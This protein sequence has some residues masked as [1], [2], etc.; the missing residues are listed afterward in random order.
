MSVFSDISEY[1]WSTLSEGK[2]YDVSL[3]E[4]TI[5]DLILLEIAKRNYH[6]LSIR[7]TSKD[8]ESKEGTDWEFW[9][10]SIRMGWVRYAVQAKKMD[11]NQ[12]SYKSLKH[13]VGDDGRLQHELLRE[14]AQATRS[15]AL[16][17]FYNIPKD[18]MIDKYW[19]CK[20]TLSIK[21]MG[22]TIANLEV[23]VR[24]I[25]KKRGKNFPTIH[26]FNTT[27]PLYCLL[28]CVS[29]YQKVVYKQ[30]PPPPSDTMTLSYS[31][32]SP[33]E[34]SYKS[35]FRI[36][37]HDINYRLDGIDMTEIVDSDELFK[38]VLHVLYPQNI[39]LPKRILVID[40]DKMNNSHHKA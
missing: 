12:Y 38:K 25:N 18:R 4:E 36:H 14:Y 37:N 19:N 27:Y 23:V 32:I 11:Y 9:I 26:T 15:I 31:G 24:A 21:K 8:K 1:V 28:E 29:S 16:Y 39:P 10:G 2:R 5:S 17:A 40:L 20:K 13:K 33:M 22:V 7:K 35:Q 34:L 6:Y 3:G 30:S